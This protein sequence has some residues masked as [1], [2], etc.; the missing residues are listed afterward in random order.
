MIGACAAFVSYL[1]NKAR[2]ARHSKH[3]TNET[4]TADFLAIVHHLRPVVLLV[5]MSGSLNFENFQLK[6]RTYDL[7]SVQIIQPGRFATT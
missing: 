7:R 6:T 1:I 3:L 2:S 5:K 4:N